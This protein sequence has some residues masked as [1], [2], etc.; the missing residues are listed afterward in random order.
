MSKPRIADLD[1]KL[2]IQSEVN[3]TNEFN[4][5][6]TT[7]TDLITVYA[8]LR[9]F[10]GGESL[11]GDQNNGFQTVTFTIRY[12]TDVTRLMRG[13]CD[14]QIYNFVSM[15]EIPGT[16]REWLDIKAELFIP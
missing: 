7:W 16:R 13:I 4:E 15:M 8:K 2:T 11:I 5:K 14:G 10:T 3:E 1:R 12:R 6:R 9:A